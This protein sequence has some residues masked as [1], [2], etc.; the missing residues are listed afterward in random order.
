MRLGTLHG[1]GTAD[2][3]IL[4]YGFTKT[5]GFGPW[6]DVMIGG[7]RRGI[8]QDDPVSSDLAAAAAAPAREQAAPLVRYSSM[9]RNSYSVKLEPQSFHQPGPAHGRSGR[10]FKMEKH[11]L[12][13][14]GQLLKDRGTSGPGRVQDWDVAGSRSR[15]ERGPSVM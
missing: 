8:F 9:V 3:T 12:A 7:L 1:E 4:K 13:A 6:A 2:L 11:S 15:L 5:R 10:A 14:Q